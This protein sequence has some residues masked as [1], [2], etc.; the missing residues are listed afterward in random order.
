MHVRKI[1]AIALALTALTVACGGDRDLESRRVIGSP[2]PS[3]REDTTTVSPPASTARGAV[4]PSDATQAPSR[5]RPATAPPPGNLASARL[6][7]TRI[8][9]MSQPT[10]LAMRRGDTGLYIAE[11]G[12]RI[13]VIRNG[14]VSSVNVLN[15]STEV[16]TGSEQGLLGLAFAPRGDKLYVN[17]TNTAGDTVVREYAFSNGRADTSTARQVL[18]VDQ[19]FA[20]HNGGNLVFGPDGYL[21]IGLGDGGSGGDP[22]G[23]GQNLESLLGKMLRI[24]PTP[25]TVES[26]TIPSNNPFVGRNGRDEIWAYGL[27]NPWRYSF[28]RIT[29]DLWT[30]DVGQNAWEEVDFQRAASRGGDNYGWNRMEGNHAFSGSAPAG[31]HAPIY[32]YS[33]SGG[34]C[35]VTGGYVY[36]GSHISNLRGAYVFGDH[37]AGRL[38]AFIQD[39]GK[40]INHRFLGPRV[41]SLSSFGQDASGELYA[42]SLSGGVYRIDPA[43]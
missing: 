39:G 16:S 40:A 18:M 20:N 15:I 31:H 1:A 23:N 13:R 25:S 10:A 21:Y 9:S 28:D 12:G 29:G 42:L 32:E 4:V 19:P 7:L 43:S 8:A 24:N 37:C 5:R 17:F 41:E 26:Y 2:E 27:R 36:R 34:N 6:K 14:V 3:D 22:M 38:R 11:K 35:S 30:A 33:H